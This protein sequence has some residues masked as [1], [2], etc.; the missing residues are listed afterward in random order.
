MPGS[1]PRNSSARD[2]SPRSGSFVIRRVDVMAAFVMIGLLLSAS[3]VAVVV[4]LNQGSGQ[5]VV[6]QAGTP[7]GQVAGAAQGGTPSH[8]ARP[9]R[10]A[11]SSPAP[12]VSPAITST[13]EAPFP[14]SYDSTAPSPQGATANNAS[15][16][17]WT[18]NISGGDTALLVAVAVGRLDDS[19]LSASATDDGTAMAALAEVQDNNRPDGFLEVFGLAGVPDGTN[20]ILVTVTGGPATQITGG[21]ESFTGA[22]QTGTFTTATAAGDGATPAVSIASRTGGL[23]AAFAASGSP[24]LGTSPSAAQKFIADD[25]DTTGAGNSA[26]AASAA[27]GSTVT[28]A[29]SAL[30]DFWSAVAVL[31][32]N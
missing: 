12:T 22:A 29:W 27:T 1:S 13:P 4:E 16:L 32:N 28:V 26:G 21:S 30:A 24:I 9:S 31:V 6:G 8:P 7:R 19:G 23:V 2:S 10:P 20:T 11:P 17:S 3:V 25:N 14:V 18:H 15:T 5:V